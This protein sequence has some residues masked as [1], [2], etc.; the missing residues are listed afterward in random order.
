MLK[1]KLKNLLVNQSLQEAREQDGELAAEVQEILSNL[2][3]TALES[4]MEIENTAMAD[5]WQNIDSGEFPKEIKKLARKALHRLSTKGIKPSSPLILKKES[6]LPPPDFKESYASEVDAEGNQLLL[7]VFSDKLGGLTTTYFLGDESLGFKDV[8]VQATNR[9]LLQAYLEHYE[10]HHIHMTALGLEE[11]CWLVYRY[12][13]IN[14]RGQ[15]S[16]PPA[17]PSAQKLLGGSEGL[18]ELCPLYA[19]FSWPNA[20]EEAAYLSRA[21]QFLTPGEKTW[22]LPE[23]WVIAWKQKYEETKAGV[24]VVNQTIKQE[25]LKEIISQACKNLMDEEFSPKMK[26]RLESWACL[27]WAQGNPE[28]AK[29]VLAAAHALEEEPSGQNNLLIQSIVKSSLEGAEAAACHHGHKPHEHKK[30][31]EGWS[32]SLWVPGKR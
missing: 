12:R 4:I 9:K 29:G 10:D 16:L 3:S 5:L 8:K 26:G 6:A 22:W 27:L 30:E 21:E 18:S 28:K 13:Q 19:Q 25:Q 23:G 24:L 15:K 17:Y 2:S 7:G 20:E 31:K 32:S 14:E 11:F 1:V